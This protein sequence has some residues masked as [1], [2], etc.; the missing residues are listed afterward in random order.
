ML[1][2][3]SCR[4]EGCT[5]PNAINY[6][7][8]ADQQSYDCKYL[9]PPSLLAPADKNSIANSAVT[10]K[11]EKS[12]FATAYIFQ[13]AEDSLFQNLFYNN[14]EEGLTAT[15]NNFAHAKKYYWR[16]KSLKGELTKSVFSDAKSFQINL[17][18]TPPEVKTLSISNITL[19]SAICSGSI[20]SD[21]GASI[22]E[23]GICYGTNANPSIMDSKTINGSGTGNFSGNLNNLN[24]GTTYYAR[25][26]ATN[27]KGTAYGSVLEFKTYSSFV[28]FSRYELNTDNNNDGFINKGED[29]SLKVYL[30]NTGTSP[31]N[32]VIGKIS[33]TSN[34]ISTFSQPYTSFNTILAES[35]SSYYTNISFKVSDLTPPGTV[36]TFNIA[37]TDA[38]NN[39]STESFTITVVSTKAEVHFSRYELNSENNKDGFIN[40]GEEVSLKVYLKNT[41]TSQANGVIGKISCTDNYISA[42]S[43]PYNSFSNI[44]SGSE[45]GYYTTISFKVSS[46]TP[47]GTVI[48]FNIAI[49]DESN[50]TWADSF[51]ATGY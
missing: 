22:I 26:Y 3:Y 4:R 33:C 7:P 11:W 25:A 24:K 5:D 50:N 47:P 39:T 27:S 6:D 10:F 30:K 15:V 20:S 46:L 44:L 1:L 16:V 31:V 34:Y 29:I 48:T 51:T 8:K 32:G 14:Q 13:V 21:G 9:Q 28:H 17:N 42:F 23:R 41:G 19:L 12:D 2:V 36:I 40:K 49:T 18:A 45:S 43:Q 38:S 37:I 35:E